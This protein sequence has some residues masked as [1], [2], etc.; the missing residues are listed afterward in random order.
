VSVLAAAPDNRT[1]AAAGDDGFVRFW[2]YADGK[3]GETIGAHAGP[4]A[5]LSYH[6]DG[7]LVTASPDGSVKMWRS[8]SEGPKLYAHPDPLTA[9]FLSVDGGRLLTAC[10]DKQIRLWDVGA[11][12]ADKM[13]IAWNAADGKEVAK[14]AG[15]SAP[16]RA[17]TLTS[18]GK[19]AAAGLEDGSVRL[20]DLT[21]GK[22]VK[23]LPGHVGAVNAVAYLPKGDQLATAGADKTVRLFN[24]ADGAEKRKLEVAA[25]ATS[26]ALN[27]D[28][29]ILAAGSDRSVTVWNLADG[30][31]TASWTTPA[32]VRGVGFSTDASRV[33]VAG[34]DGRVRLYTTLGALEE[35]FAHDGPAV[36][37]AVHPDG[38]RIVSAAADKSAR[39]WTPSLLWQAKHAG[40]V[41]QALVSPR[42]DRVYSAGDDKT[43]AAWNAADGKAAATIPHSA[44][45]VLLTMSGDGGRFASVAADKTLRVWG[46]D[47]ADKPL[48]TTLPGTASYAALSPNG[49]RVAVALSGE[50]ANSVHI[51]DAPTQ[52]AAE[53]AQLRDVQT[54]IE[55]ATAVRGL[56]YLGDNR[57]L[58]TASNDKT[59]RL[60][61]AG[62]AAAWA[63]HAGGVAGAV[64]ASNGA[65]VVSGGADK[66]LKLWDIATGKL[67]RTFGPTAD[68]VSGVALSRD[69]TKVAAAAGVNAVVW[70]MADGKQLATLV[71]PAAVA[72]V[73]FGGDSGRLA[74]AAAD[75]QARVWDLASGRELQSFA[76]DGPVRAVAL[77]G[78]NTDLVSAGADKSIRVRPV[79]AKAVVAT[80]FPAAALAASA[81][82][83]RVLTANADGKTRIWNANDYKLER[84][85][86]GGSKPATAVAVDRN[87]LL[88]AVGDADGVIR[89]YDFTQGILVGQ[90]KAP[91]AI[92]SL[93]FSPNNEMVTACTG[94]TAT[95]WRIAYERGQPTSPDFGKK[96]QTVDHPAPTSS[97]VW[98]PDGLTFY[99]AAGDKDVRCWKF[100]G[101]AAVRSFGFPNLLDAVAFNPSGTVLAAASHDTTARLFDVAKGQEI[102]QIKASP[103]P[104]PEPIYCLAWTPDGK[105]FATGGLDAAVRLWDAE[106][107]N[108]VREFR[109]FKEK[110]FE[111][112]HRAGVNSIAFSPDGKLLATAGGDRTVKLWNVADGSVVRELVNPD[113]KPAGSS[114]PGDVN[115]VRFAADG[116]FLL[117]AG[118]APGRKGFLTVWN[119]ADGKVASAEELPFGGVFSL[120]VAPDGKRLALGTGPSDGSTPN[121]YIIKMPTAVK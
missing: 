3:F 35:F 99:T 22:E 74:T 93:A 57:T 54:L 37:A 120:A 66:T 7:R 80:G 50:P 96:I 52:L 82:G 95:T 67:V 107:G 112:G 110:E 12:G 8:P 53:G 26:L 86:D 10:A 19:F 23:N 15:L 83:G 102:R 31:Q 62:V 105:Q 27:K 34:A 36:F 42:G 97:I 39:L 111:K 25:A 90:V 70:N 61:D 88:A 121:G 76:H 77:H 72:G 81:D 115:A 59:L 4:V 108:L 119:V 40:A 49:L 48:T 47:A 16:V 75:A 113:L 43:V 44:P 21:M 41:R 9:A 45:V 100:V 63:A 65:Q 56:A 55:H 84:T 20:F 69:G 91:G 58:L 116:R 79:L 28:C 64:L 117:S 106:N 71:H 87:S 32:E 2:N 94:S 92:A 5:S 1:L 14:F 60:T 13:L 109:A 51:Y 73:S 89:I 68:A 6:G 85:L 101:E 33:V 118:A 30:K 38:K 78:N 46:V 24:V 29:S 104:K 18:D 98:A 11:G 103:G 17:V 114:H